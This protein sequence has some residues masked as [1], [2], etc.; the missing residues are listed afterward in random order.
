MEL[1]QCKP[2][3]KL[4]IPNMDY[5][6]NKHTE[7]VTLHDL[8]I[9][10]KGMYIISITINTNNSKIQKIDCSSKTILVKEKRTSAIRTQYNDSNIILKFGGNFTLNHKILNEYKTILYNCFILQNGLNLKSEIIF[11][12]NEN[13][14]FLTVN[15][16]EESVLKLIPNFENFSITGDFILKSAIINPKYFTIYNLQQVPYIIK[17][18]D[19]QNY[20][21][22]LKRRF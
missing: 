10:K 18:N 17:E 14:F 22:V 20:D 11:Q 1:G 21:M 8:R 12:E 19:S 3:G 9:T 13:Q 6:F 5:K 4:L 16:P 7:V 15:D 2:E